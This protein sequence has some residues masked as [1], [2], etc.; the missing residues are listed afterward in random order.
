M[1]KTQFEM[2]AR[3]IIIIF[4]LYLMKPIMN[5]WNGWILLK[6]LMPIILI[7]WI[8]LPL[9]DLKIW[10]KKKNATK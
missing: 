7:I 3:A 2:L 4:I 1:L 9:F 6:Y 5:D 10:E 8:F